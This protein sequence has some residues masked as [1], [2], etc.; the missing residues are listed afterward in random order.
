MQ[1]AVFKHAEG[2][3]YHGGAVA[4]ALVAYGLGLLGLFSGGPI[5]GVGAPGFVQLP[6]I[7][8]QQVKTTVTVPDGGTLLIGGQ[9]LTFESE[10]EAGVPILSKIPIIKRLYSSKA[11]VKD[12]QVLLILIKPEILIKEEQEELAHPT[13]GS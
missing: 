8:R 13:L 1:D 12:E 6:I 7:Q 10:R 5:T 3:L 4:Y 2:L 11:V 9:K